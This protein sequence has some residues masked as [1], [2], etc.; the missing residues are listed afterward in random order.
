MIENS[1]TNY[2]DDRCDQNLLM[3]WYCNGIV[4]QKSTFP[5][6]ICIMSHYNSD[7]YSKFVDINAAF[8]TSAASVVVLLYWTTLLLDKIVIEPER[9]KLVHL[10]L[11]HN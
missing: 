9:E 10:K 3:E 4:L 7:I 5:S 11:V 2:F 6:T 8:D 1:K